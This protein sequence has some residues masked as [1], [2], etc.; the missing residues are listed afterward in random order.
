M[1]CMNYLT[2]QCK[3]SRQYKI[4]YTLSPRSHNQTWSVF[5]Q[6]NLDK[7]LG[8]MTASSVTCINWNFSKFSFNYH[9]DTRKSKQPHIQTHT[10]ALITQEYTVYALIF[11]YK[12]CC[13][14]T[15]IMEKLVY[16]NSATQY[17]YSTV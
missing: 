14:Q 5:T 11:F 13:C 10:S 8:H 16:S 3:Q 2:Y 12:Q 4:I 7:Q 9:R 15:P 6:H 1:K 17:C